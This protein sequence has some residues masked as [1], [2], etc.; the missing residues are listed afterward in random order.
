MSMVVQVTSGE[1]I[2]GP[3]GVEVSLLPVGRADEDTRIRYVY[4]TR[5]GR[6]VICQQCSMNWT[7]KGYFTKVLVKFSC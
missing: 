5:E 1:N 7:Y 3:E 6:C 2:F 4:T